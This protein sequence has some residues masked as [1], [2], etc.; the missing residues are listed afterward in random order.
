ML[1]R[2]WLGHGN[3]P[4]MFF[5]N[6]RRHFGAANAGAT[7]IKAGIDAVV[8]AAIIPAARAIRSRLSSI[9]SACAGAGIL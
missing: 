9:R 5:E 2:D 4:P 3:V 1:V 7:R 6:E 8:A